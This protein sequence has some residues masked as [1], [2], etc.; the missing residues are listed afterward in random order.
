MLSIGLA[1]P[2]RRHHSCY[3]VAGSLCDV[4][5]HHKA[6]DAPLS[7]ASNSFLNPLSIS[8]VCLSSCIF[9]LETFCSLPIFFTMAEVDNNFPRPRSSLLMPLVTSTCKPSMA[10]TYSAFKQ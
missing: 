6:H 1:Q 8:A 4:A 10:D 5:C 2:G 7:S 9:S 3:V